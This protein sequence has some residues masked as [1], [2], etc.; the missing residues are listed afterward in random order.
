MVQGR[1]MVGQQLRRENRTA[2]RQAAW[3][4]LA[5]NSNRLRKA[6]S[7]DKRGHHNP[8]ARTASVACDHDDD[9][10]RMPRM[11]Q[12]HVED[13]VAGHM[14]CLHIVAALV[15]SHRTKGAAA[16]IRIRPGLVV[17]QGQ[18]VA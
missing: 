18:R 6:A 5:G 1:W 3:P 17:E 12:V 9:D 7:V 8:A 11:I 15:D 13:I 10:A 16:G 2:D 4:A 14:G